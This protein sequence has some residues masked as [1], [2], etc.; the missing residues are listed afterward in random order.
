MPGIS[1]G[2]GEKKEDRQPAMHA[3]LY[4]RQGTTGVK[5]K[6]AKLREGLL[7]QREQSF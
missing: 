6:K 3:L 2:G 5:K 4:R 1:A 7:P